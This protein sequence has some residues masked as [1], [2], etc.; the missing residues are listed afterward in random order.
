LEGCK[1]GL[2]GL[3]ECTAE[4]PRNGGVDE[5]ATAHNDATARGILNEVEVMRGKNPKSPEWEAA[6]LD[7]VKE[8]THLL[9]LCPINSFHK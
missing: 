2:E 9:V 6:L 4:C 1:E 5:L 7:K 3:R 8:R